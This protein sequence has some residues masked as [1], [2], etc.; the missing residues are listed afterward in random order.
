MAAIQETRVSP[1]VAGAFVVAV[2]AALLVG[3]AGG[4][5]LRAASS[6]GLA[7]PAQTVQNEAVKAAELP[8]SVQAYMAAAEEPQF[9]VDEFIR[10]LGYAK[11]AE[12][13]AWVQAYT[14]P[15]D[16]PRLKVDELIRSLNNSNTSGRATD[17]TSIGNPVP[18]RTTGDRE[19]A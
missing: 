18:E 19:K 12:L 2:A 15:A 1:S 7:A 8:A 4:Y 13:P 10:S 3:G 14:A 5:V 16:E 9:K 17:L 6:Q 11:P